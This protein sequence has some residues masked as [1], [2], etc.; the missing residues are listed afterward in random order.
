MSESYLP[1][2]WFP[3]PLPGN[4]VIGDGSWFYSTYALRNFHSRRPC[5][6]GVGRN[7][8]VYIHTF[9]DLGPDGEV[10][11]GDFCT[12]SGPVFSTNARV[13]VG[14]RVLISE[15]VV[16]ADHF[17]TTP[18]TPGPRGG[19]DPEGSAATIV[20]GDDGW[21]GT[22]AVILAGARLGTGVIVG[23]GAVVDLEVPPYAIVA[24]NPARVVGWARPGGGRAATPPPEAH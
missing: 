24:G 18:F 1:H 20:I 16:I 8:G 3:S 23:A 9:F 10:R 15:E 11:I 17:V 22:R 4:V 19:R 5:G 12:I 2:D 7:T 14:D 13:E 21:I 6:L